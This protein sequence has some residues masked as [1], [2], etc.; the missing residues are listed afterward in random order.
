[1]APGVPQNSLM[2]NDFT[3]QLYTSEG[4]MHLANVPTPADSS[5]LPLK[6][7]EGLRKLSLSAKKSVDVI[8]VILADDRTIG[9]NVNSA[10]SGAVILGTICVE[11]VKIYLDELR[12]FMCAELPFLPAAFNFLTKDGWPV[13]K[14]QEPKISSSHVVRENNC[15]YIKKEFEK[16]RVGIVTSGGVS[17]GF[18]FTDLNINIKQLRETIEQQLKVSEQSRIDYRFLE[19]NGWPVMPNQESTL[20]LTDIMFLGQIVR[21]QYGERNFAITDSARPTSLLLNG[22]NLVIENR[23]PSPSQENSEHEQVKRKKSLKFSRDTQS[24]V[25]VR[26]E[27]EKRPRIGKENLVKPI[28]I[29]YVRAEAAQYA[30][31]LKVELVSMGFS[32]YLDVHEIKTGSDWQDALNHA[33]THCYLFVPLITPMYGKTLWTNREIKLAD[34]LGKRIIPVNLMENWPPACLAIQFASTQYIPWKLQESDHVKEPEKPSDSKTWDSTCLKRV[35]RQIAECY[36][37][38]RSPPRRIPSTKEITPVAVCKPLR[39]DV[40]S[41]MRDEYFDD[42]KQSIVISA[43]PRQKYIAEDLKALFEKNGREVWC[44]VDLLDSQVNLGSEDITVTDP[45]TPR[46]LPTIQ[47]GDVFFSQNDIEF[48]SS[49]GD[50]KSLPEAYGRRPLS[51]LMSQFSDISQPST[52]SREKLDH[53]KTF[54]QKVDQAAVIIVLVSEAYTKSTFSHQQVFYCEHRKRVV[55]VRCD[56]A[57]IPKWFRLLMG[58]DMITKVNNPQFECVL[59]ARVKRAINPSSSETPKDATAEAKMNYL[60]NFLKRNL[61]LQDMCVYIAG[62]SKLQSQRSEDICRAIGRELAK[63][64]RASLVTG[65]F[66]GAADITAKTFSECR[67]NNNQ[68]LKDESAVVHILPISDSE[69]LTAKACQ[70]PDGSFEAVPYGKTVFLGDSVKERETVVARLL[71]TC[72]VIEGGPGVVHE[73]EEFIWN[74]HFVI[75]IM[76][77][78]GAAGGNY[79]VPV[80]IFEV[81]PGVDEIDWSVLSDIEATPEAVATAVVNIIFSLKKSL[82]SPTNTLQKS[83]AILKRKSRRKLKSRKQKAVDQD[84]Q[85]MEILPPFTKVPLSVMR[86]AFERE[87]SEV[88]Q[89]SSDEPNSIIKVKRCWWR[90]FLNVTFWKNKNRRKHKIET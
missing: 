76:S 48:Y 17:L 22:G 59:K 16:P 44:S 1:M 43:H 6:N 46:N 70:N 26:K 72:I 25:K 85:D 68:F 35:A 50:K 63:V 75:P 38:C 12:R 36:K 54:Q 49:V 34:V 32:V 5:N 77:T 8:G 69:D 24:S 47:E 40:Y 9:K 23:L 89:C 52:L 67:E 86:N 66:F 71:D 11:N 79:G 73:V 65:G 82:S 42:S 64:E 41:Y 14:Q 13:L 84:F 78:G 87:T 57:P 18:V 10:D 27:S 80:R 19:R 56:A 74:D 37:D 15:I 83:N 3:P 55:L 61:P 45:N 21:I 31:D 29:S 33:V 51:R 39:D 58:N 62:S 20:S 28:L 4:T 7:C 60:V 81:P 90:R 30:L 88:S 53:L 2:P